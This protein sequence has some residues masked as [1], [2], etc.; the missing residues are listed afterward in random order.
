[1]RPSAAASRRAPSARRRPEP[2]APRL[3]LKQARAA[4]DQLQAL[5]MEGLRR[6]AYV[7]Q[8]VGLGQTLRLWH[9]YLCF[10]DRVFIVN[11][12]ILQASAWRVLRSRAPPCPAPTPCRQA[13]VGL[14]VG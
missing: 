7:D 13:L 5:Q 3:L 8:A 14:A 11:L 4:G 12:K 6:L 1:M 10:P 9:R 2:R